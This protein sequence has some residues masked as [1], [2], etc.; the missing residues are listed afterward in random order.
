MVFS[1]AVIYGLQPSSYFDQRN[2]IR[3]IL[4][5]HKKYFPLHSSDDATYFKLRKFQLLYNCKISVLP[6]ASFN[7]FVKLKI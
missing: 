3:E 2:I 4:F 7:P 6:W 1:S 5:I